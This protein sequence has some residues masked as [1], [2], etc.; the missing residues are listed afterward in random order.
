VKTII[1]SIT[2]AA[3]LAPCLI[4]NANASDW[5][6]K[7]SVGQ[8]EA[9][10]SGVAL[11][12]GLAYGGA[13]GT[14]IGPVR[15]EAGVTHLSGDFA[16][17][18]DADALTYSATGYLDLPVG[19]HASV[20]AGAGIDYIDGEA[21]VFG[22]T[23]DASGEGYHWSVGGAYRLSERMIAEAMFTQTTADLDTDFGGVDLEA[24]TVTLGLRFAL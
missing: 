4:S 14:S 9:D 2:A 23:L 24:N 20:F 5:Y 11:D 16:G 13:V 22:S 19:A 6:G 17:I 10:I 21:N 15:V 8:T 1:Q 7:V 12:E 18:V 3:I